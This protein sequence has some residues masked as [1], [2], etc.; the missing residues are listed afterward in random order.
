MSTVRWII[1][2]SIASGLLVILLA[3]VIRSIARIAKPLGAI[4]AVGF[5][6]R[7]VAAL[8][9]FWISYLQ[10][11]VLSS[12]QLGRGFWR[13]ALDAFVYYDIALYAAEG[14]R[15][16]PPDAA[17]K[18][19]VDLL[20]LWLWVFGTSPFSPVLL[21]L[22]CYVG[23]CALLVAALRGLPKEWLLKAGA[24][25]LLAVSLSPMS[26]FVSAQALKDALFLLF[27]VVLSAGVWL[28]TR[29]LSD[30]SLTWREVVPGLLAIS[31]GS[32]VTAGIRV[33]YPA[34]NAV[35][36]G[37]A[38]LSIV[39]VKR[40]ARWGLFA[41][42][43]AAL[44]ALTLSAVLLGSPEGSHYMRLLLGMGTT[45][46][47]QMMEQSRLGFARTGGSTNVAAATE[48]DGV[49]GSWQS[50]PATVGGYARALGVGVATLFV[51]LLVLNAL[52]IVN[53]TG[54]LAMMAVG[55]LDT[56]FFD[57]VVASTAWLAWGLWRERRPNV[58]YLVFAITLAL[59]LIVLMGYIVTNVG[60]LVR[61]RL[62][63]LVPSST[64]L[65]AFASAPAFIASDAAAAEPAVSGSR[66]RKA[67]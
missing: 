4:V 29:V 35:A 5:G 41:G 9:L 47:A 17:S 20:A 11:P 52:S 53:V 50:H 46:P 7:L 67:G 38:L 2:P 56:I 18:A 30:P 37:A 45:S 16:V 39:L 57:I 36:M 44:A 63:L 54:G 64:L 15:F 12:L 42:S 43:S 27:A 26:L 1:L 51:P 23:T 40:H 55:D 59:L 34:I 31:V 58:P 10:L 21:N 62:M 60:T 65:L 32:Y 19:Y 25:L 28:L 3:A 22:T 61:L 49:P 66:P 8:G 48:R 14:G 24:V 13:M 33:Y 6:L